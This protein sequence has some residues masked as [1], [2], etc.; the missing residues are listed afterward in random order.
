MDL[1]IIIVNYKSKL[2]TAHC[3]EAIFK[4]DLKSL[5]FEVI[6]VDNASGDNLDDMMGGRPEL[7]LIYS[8]GN[9]GMG[10]GNNLGIKEAKGKYV[11]ILNPDTVVYSNAIY[12]LFYYLETH[13]EVYIVGPKLLNTDGTL[14][15]SCS[16]FPKVYTPILRRTFLGEYF[17]SN[18]DS[19]MMTDFDHADIREVDWLMGSCLLVRHDGWE[20]FDER[21]FMYFEDI[22]VCRRAWRF[23]KKVVYNPRATVIHDHARESAKNPWYIAPFTDKLTREHIKSWIKYFWK[24]QTKP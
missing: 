2:K 10:G 12:I 8:S 19:F 16:R 11:L 17:K 1:S 3:L 14:Q 6:L 21:F 20:G 4:S 24:W 22:D 13:P 15:A 9:L 7:K 18:R 23:Q 5:K